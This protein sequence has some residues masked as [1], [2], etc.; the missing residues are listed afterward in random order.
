MK[1]VIEKIVGGLSGILLAALVLAGCSDLNEPKNDVR[2]GGKVKISFSVGNLDSRTIMPLNLTEDEVVK[3]VITAKQLQING[4]YSAY[5]FDEKE[6]LEWEAGLKNGTQLNALDMMRADS[7]TLD[8]G[9]YNFTLELYADI[10]GT[11]SVVQAGE[12]LA[13]TIESDGN[14]IVFDEMSY[15]RECGDLAITLTWDYTEGRNPIG[16]V[17]AGL[18][19]LESKGVDS[20]LD[21]SENPVELTIIAESDSASVNYTVLD[22]PN[23]S[24][25]LKIKLYDSEDTTKLLNTISDIVKIHG[26]KTKKTIELDLEKVNVL[27][28]VSY[29]LNGGSWGEGEEESK[30]D[31]RRNAYTAVALDEEIPV[32]EGFEF[33]GWYTDEDCTDENEISEISAGLESA[34]DYT[35]YAKWNKTEE[36][37]ISVTLKVDETSDISFVPNANNELVTIDGKNIIIT[38]V[39]EVGEGESKKSLETYTWKVDGEVQTSNENTLRIDASA[40]PSG[41]YTISLIAVD[42][43]G[44]YY[45]CLA[46][47]EWKR[48]Y[49][50]TFDTTNAPS[51]VDLSGFAEQLAQQYVIEGSRVVEPE[52]VVTGETTIDYA[53]TYGWYTDSKFT[54][55]FDFNVTPTQNLTLYGCWDIDTIYVGQ[56]GSSG[57]GRGTAAMP[58][59]TVADAVALMNDSSKDYTIVIDGEVSGGQIIAD[60]NDNGVITV[61]AANSITLRGKTS[62]EKD[63]LKGAGTGPVLSVTTGTPIT[64]ENLTITGGISE[65]QNGGGIILNAG[66]KL[67]LGEGAL[68]TGNTAEVRG[69]GIYAAGDHIEIT[70]NSGAKVTNNS[71]THSGETVDGDYIYDGGAGIF[72]SGDGIADTDTL[73]V[74]VVNEGAEIGANFSPYLRRGGGVHVNNAKMQI[75]GGMITGNVAGD[76]AANVYVNGANSLVTMTSG[77]ISYGQA[78]ST[79]CWGTN[80]YGGGLVLHGGK[81]TMSGGKICNNMAKPDAGAAGNSAGVLIGSNCT[82]EMTGGE[83]SKNYVVDSGTCTIKG[84]AVCLDN[85]SSV[86][87]IGG[88]AV[89]RSDAETGIGN[90]DVYLGYTE[91]SNHNVVGYAKIT[92]IGEL[93][94]STVATITP[95]AYDASVTWLEVSNVT[96]EGMTSTTLGKECGKFAVTPTTATNYLLTKDGKLVDYNA[97]ASTVASYIENMSES[98]TVR[99]AGAID[100]ATL[101][102]IR[103]A[104]MSLSS[105]NTIEVDLDLSYATGL[106]S[107]PSYSFYEN[108]VGCQNLTS[109]LLPEGVTSIGELAFCSCTKLTTINIPS[110]VTTIYARAFN[111]CSSLA[112]VTLADGNKN[113]KLAEDGAI[114]TINGTKL[115]MYGNKTATGTFAVPNTVTEIGTYAFSHCN[116]ENVTFGA[117]SAL[118]SIGGEAFFKCRKLASINLPDNVSSIG[119]EAFMYCSS[120]TSITLP[121]SLTAIA[122]QTFNSCSSLTTV[123]IPVSVK[124][125]GNWAF[126]STALTTVNYKGTEEQ[127]D[128]MTIASSAFNGRDNVTWVYNYKIGSKT[129][130]DAVGDIVF[131]DGSAIAYTDGLTLTADQK[132]AAVAVIFYVGT[133]SDALGARKL[134]IG[135]HNSFEEKDGTNTGRYR[136][137]TSTTGIN[138]T[139]TNILVTRS[140]GTTAPVEPYI[141]YIYNSGQNE[142]VSGD[143]NGSDNWE[144]ICKVD[145]SAELSD[146][147][148]FNWANNYGAKFNLTGSYASGWYLPSAAEMVALWTNLYSG[149]KMINTILPAIGGTELAAGDAGDNYDYLTANRANT[150][151]GSLTYLW[152]YVGFDTGAPCTE[153]VS[154]STNLAGEGYVCAI[155]EF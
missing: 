83:I 18:Y 78:D 135:I 42:E 146:Y 93:S 89:I 64:I 118:T 116:F 117:D 85:A 82:F 76:C 108:N 52:L 22:V 58:L 141:S 25:L 144:E 49:T 128:A 112:N 123:T 5:S 69:G 47:V 88:T 2:T 10:N 34:H 36:T 8:T 154:P 105:S 74:L 62:N 142:Y 38:A 92:I 125:I 54:E 68:I 104:L 134:G 65:G 3:A 53:P 132:A 59:R 101:T 60:T 41:V 24:Y 15:V 133:S 109:V 29:N 61:I 131:N 72:I 56:N 16:K 32:R 137:T 102:T 121:E 84:G 67:T 113:L 110:T 1:K 136:W 71:L 139:F 98:G 153:G 99:L 140:S 63:S 130:P 148:V 122:T 81:F 150:V 44:E 79:D 77:E 90:N 35:L 50:I 45:S 43:A 26:F 96:Q 94:A 28:K 143:L 70:M 19:T 151:S 145:T 126:E 20:A 51:T 152:S 114:Y 30:N 129:A 13:K 115:V 39:T 37:G 95:S 119:H 21:Y 138:T 147:P 87:R 91:D 33:G 4:E 107:V 48:K 155:R 103:D 120:F 23:G 55:L 97:T 111:E 124:E 80:A 86:F 46:Q 149:N 127:K 100:T 57:T 12:I 75:A 66:A 31:T 106:T 9:T 7:V 14:T 27:Y 11:E 17:V 73:P 40:Y 6:S